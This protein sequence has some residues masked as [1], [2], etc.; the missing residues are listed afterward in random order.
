MPFVRIELLAGKTTSFKHALLDEVH[1]ALVEAFRIPDHDRTQRLFE[2]QPD[3][4]EF[5]KDRRP[6]PILI[7]I[8]CF[9]GRS[10]A[11]KQLLYR[12]MAERLQQRLGVEP[13]NV[14]VVLKEV[15]RQNWGFAGQAADQ[16][17]FGFKVDV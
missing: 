10:T 11:A 12:R 15:P 4:F 13:R 16:I 14:C 1:A 17:D 3:A 2:L 6:D 7:E 9:T 5:P 8:A